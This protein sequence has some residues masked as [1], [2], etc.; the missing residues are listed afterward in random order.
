MSGPVSEA[1]RIKQIRLKILGVLE[2]LG[3]KEEVLDV[4]R[5]DV[6]L[7]GTTTYFIRGFVYEVE[8]E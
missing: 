6:N 7:S 5:S 1:D 3:L 4:G 2:E 8:A